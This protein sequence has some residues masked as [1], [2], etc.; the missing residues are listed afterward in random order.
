MLGAL[1]TTI[2][3]VGVVWF[4]VLLLGDFFFVYFLAF[5]T[6]VSLRNLKNQM[7][8]S[9]EHAIKTSFS[10]TPTSYLFTLLSEMYLAIKDKSLLP[11]IM[12]LVD[13]VNRR[14]DTRVE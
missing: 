13:F 5:I 10:L 4:N 9:L 11:T 3:V 8:Q 2:L 7:T 6:S 12:R 14:W 1:I